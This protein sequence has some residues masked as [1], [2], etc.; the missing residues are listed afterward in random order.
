VVEPARGGRQPDRPRL[1][2]VAERCDPLAATPHAPR[3][4]GERRAQPELR[5]VGQLDL[6][7][8]KDA[9]AVAGDHRAFARLLT[10][11]YAGATQAREPPF[12]LACDAAHDVLQA[13][14][15]E[16]RERAVAVAQ[17]VALLEVWGGELALDERLDRRAEVARAGRR[18][19]SDV[20][21]ARHRRK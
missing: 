5:T 14:L 12:A 4:A 3:L 15:A 11:L 16:Q 17:Q 13:Q 18:R 2:R 10:H 6:P 7:T 19:V 1:P 21:F 20:P 8:G 9:G